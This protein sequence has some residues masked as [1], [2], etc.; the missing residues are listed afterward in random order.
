MTTIEL[1]ESGGENDS[2]AFVLK[3]ASPAIANALR[4]IV[5]NHVPTMAIE[6]VEF[7]KNSSVLYDEIIAHRLG[8]V[9]L[10][11]DLQTYNLPSECKCKAEGCAS[12]QTKI[13]LKAEG[14]CT[15][16]ASD[17]KPKDPEIKPVHPDMPIVK[18]LKKQPLEL[19]ATAVLGIGKEHSKWSPAHVYYKQKPVLK[20]GNLKNPEA[21]VQAAPS[22]VFELKGGKLVA[23]ERLLMK[24]DLAG[25]VEDAS[26]GKAAVEGSNDYAFYLESF[27]QL[28]C[29]QIMEKAAE[30]LEKQL[31]EFG[32]LLK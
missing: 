28:S 32:K 20:A 19:E 9:P 31:K 14:P 27:G 18:L 6:D 13:T 4:R 16:F 1:I 25:L 29:K 12:C 10:K 21:V 24:Y 22:G 11:T 5:L 30:I 26:D 3:E 2:V 15:V 17:L 7:R 8:L 23:N